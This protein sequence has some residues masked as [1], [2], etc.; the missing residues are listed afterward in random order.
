[1]CR[2]G[3]DQPLRRRHLRYPGIDG[4][5][6]TE[7]F[8]V[9][10]AGHAVG[11]VQRY[12]FS[13]ES[14]WTSILADALASPGPAIEPGIDPKTAIGID[15]AIGDLTATGRGVGTAAISL[16][17]A[18]IFATYSDID[19]IV[20]SMQ[21]ANRSSWRTLERVGFKRRWAG[22]L[23]SPDPSDAGPTFVYVRHRD[24]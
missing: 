19:W 20:V 11:F 2:H 22:L 18:D 24:W 1:G 14:E 9:E 15:Y 21:Q 12:L 10:E 16:F 5:D 6:Q 13:A 23:D 7:Y 17:V 8:V 3:R 4:D